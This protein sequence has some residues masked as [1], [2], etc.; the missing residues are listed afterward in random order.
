MSDSETFKGLSKRATV[1][2]TFDRS[3][4][5]AEFGDSPPFRLPVVTSMTLGRPMT[6]NRCSTAYLQHLGV[7]CPGGR[8]FLRYCSSV[9]CSIQS[10]TLPL[11]RS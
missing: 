5:A 2:G 11:S 7:G 6:S 9:T 4:Q 1:R 10:T 8:Y 3:A